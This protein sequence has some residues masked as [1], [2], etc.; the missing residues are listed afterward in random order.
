MPASTPASGVLREQPA[1]T[2]ASA[3]TRLTS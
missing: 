1:S 2:N 3:T